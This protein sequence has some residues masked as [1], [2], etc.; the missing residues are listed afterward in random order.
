[1]A[2]S[3]HQDPLLTNLLSNPGP[4]RST[5]D[6]PR[7][8]GEGPWSI[9]SCFLQEHPRDSTSNQR[10]EVAASNQVP[11]E[12][13]RAQ[14]GCSHA[15]ICRRNWT[16]CSRYDLYNM[17]GF[18][19]GVWRID[20]DEMNRKAIWCLTRKMARQVRRVSARSPKERR[21]QR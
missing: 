18:G 5:R 15:K 4:L 21:G 9:P 7:Q 19:C 20:V 14:G 3:I 2:L 8:I 6:L 17:I 13:S 10:M 11:R 1:M 16:R 12:R